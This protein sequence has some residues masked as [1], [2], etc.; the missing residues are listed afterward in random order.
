MMDIELKDLRMVRMIAETS[1]L[2]KAAERLN[3]SQSAL[4]R[5]LLDLE[6]RVGVSLFDRLPRQMRLTDVGQE[7]LN[8]A[9]EIL[10]KIDQTEQSIVRRRDGQAGELKVGVHCRSVYAW[11]PE[12]LKEFQ[13]RFPEVGISIISTDD[14]VRDFN[15]GKIDIVISH[16]V[17]DEA[18]KG[19]TYE[20]LFD[21]RIVVIMAPGHPLVGQELTLADFGRNDYFSVLTK[22]DDPFYN[23]YLKPAGIEPTSFTAINHGET[24]LD[25]LATSKGLALLPEILVKSLIEGG[26]LAMNVIKDV[27]ISSAWLMGHKDNQPLSLT[28]SAFI[29]IIRASM[30][31][32]GK[33]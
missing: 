12:V 25:M 26:K 17:H 30:N 29:D 13:A 19:L 31:Q 32:S 8:I 20:P 5:Q 27:P 22:T 3:I 2:T 24:M 18:Q 14:Y 9:D 4:S 33:E 6:D 1:N 23:H 16:D 21:E 7:L 15:Q 11:L 10:N 28:T